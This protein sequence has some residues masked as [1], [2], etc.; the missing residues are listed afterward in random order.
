M[1]PLAEFS[2]KIPSVTSTW[3]LHLAAAAVVFHLAL[4]SQR[5]AAL[6]LLP[7]AAIA[8]A[9]PFIHLALTD[10][11]FRAAI[12]DEMGTSY[13]VHQVTAALTPLLATFLGVAAGTEWFGRPPNS[14]GF[15][16]N[17]IERRY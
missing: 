5:R 10:H 16:V 7:P 3:S 12:L 2:D 8:W 14:K 1:Y 9:V 4:A 13:I 6:I 11:P 15:E 17:L